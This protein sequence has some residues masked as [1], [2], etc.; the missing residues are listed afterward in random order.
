[1]SVLWDYICTYLCHIVFPLSGLWEHN[2]AS[3]TKHPAREPSSHRDHPASERWKLCLAT[4]IIIWISRKIIRQAGH[5][6]IG[7]IRIVNNGKGCPASRMSRQAGSLLYNQT[8]GYRNRHFS[9]YP[10]HCY[11]DFCYPDV[12]FG[13]LVIQ[14]RFSIKCPDNKS[15]ILSIHFVRFLSFI[16]ALIIEQNKCLDNEFVSLQ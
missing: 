3:R 5:P 11:P 14:S 4:G 9:L 13:Y 12:L 10:D 2:P 16:P 7:I 8:S 1:M 6:V 15:D